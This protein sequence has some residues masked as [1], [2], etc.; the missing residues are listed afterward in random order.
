[1]TFGLARS[2]VC[3]CRPGRLN[4]L[5]GRRPPVRDAPLANTPLRARTER[6]GSPTSHTTR[7]AAR[8]ALSTLGSLSRR[9]TLDARRLTL[10]AR[11]SALGAR[12]SSPRERTRLPV[13]GVH[14]RRPTLVIT[15]AAGSWPS[16]SAFC[17]RGVQRGRGRQVQA[18][19]VVEGAVQEPCAGRATSAERRRR[20]PGSGPPPPAAPGRPCPGRWRRRRTRA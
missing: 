1:M 20:Q 11:R 5:R 18:Y 14:M 10:R 17:R 3:P 9:S 4:H 15:D 12:I 8:D 2:R 13:A 6:P 19:R 7:K 16:A